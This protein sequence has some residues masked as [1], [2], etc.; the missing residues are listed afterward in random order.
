MAN[1]RT[2]DPLII[3]GT[4]SKELARQI[5][6]EEHDEEP[7]DATPPTDTD[8]PPE[9]FRL[10][11]G[12]I[13]HHRANLTFELGRS[14]MKLRIQGQ[15]EALEWVMQQI[16]DIR[17][18]ASTEITNEPCPTCHG[19]GWVIEGQSMGF[20]S[21][22]QVECPDCG[23]VS[24]EMMQQQPGESR[25]DWKNRTFALHFGR[26]RLSQRDP[27]EQS[28]PQHNHP[29]LKADH[30]GRVFVK[31]NGKWVPITQNGASVPAGPLPNLPSRHGR[32]P[33]EGR[34]QLRPPFG[35]TRLDGGQEPVHPVPR[36]R[37]GDVA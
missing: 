24:V 27:S 29:V 17:D 8:T 6:R 1:H 3:D 33:P 11:E 23:G 9:L 18:S 34:N 2:S 10:L 28:L 32:G 15:L 21:G 19:D 30:R 4:I 20:P 14:A 7:V 13:A 35:L 25:A 22:E 31:Q 12:L 26:G 16:V 37:L 5:Y 36:G